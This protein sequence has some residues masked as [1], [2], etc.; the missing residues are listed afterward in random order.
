MNQHAE[1]AKKNVTTKRVVKTAPNESGASIEITSEAVNSVEISEG[2]NGKL[3]VIVK[4][5]NEDIDEA[6][7]DAMA[8]VIKLR[9][10]TADENKKGAS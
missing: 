3:R 7:V 5:Y 1:E 10:W 9:K 8:T 4:V 6:A 2:T